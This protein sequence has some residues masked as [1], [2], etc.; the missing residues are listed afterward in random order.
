L[1]NKNT[2]LFCNT[3]NKDKI[4][5]YDNGIILI[6]GSE[7]HGIKLKISGQ[8]LTIKTSPIVE[9]LNVATASAIALH[10]LRYLSLA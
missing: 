5:G 9:S 6:V 7:G 4:I 2:S 3:L 1:E 8:S 10:E